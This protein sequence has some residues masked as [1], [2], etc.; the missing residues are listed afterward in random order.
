MIRLRVRYARRPD[1]GVAMLF[2]IAMGLIVTALIVAMLS[3][4]LQA[5]TTTRQHRNITSAQGAAEAGIDD[6]V[7]QLG[8]YTNGVLMEVECRAAKP[9]VLCCTYE[10]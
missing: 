9:E 3:T 6:A 7:Y 10:L 8:L 4:V 5:Q 1:D 2:V